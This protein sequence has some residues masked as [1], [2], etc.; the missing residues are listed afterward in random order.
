M[1]TSG[2]HFIGPL[3]YFIT[4]PGSLQTIEFASE[5]GGGNPPLKTRTAEG[6]SLTLY[7]SF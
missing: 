3:N 1:F 4:F 7:L 6:L 2:R 5:K